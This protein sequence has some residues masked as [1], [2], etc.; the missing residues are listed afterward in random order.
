VFGPVPSRRLGRSLGV[1]LIPRKLCSYDCVYCQVGRTTTHTI[2]RGVYAPTELVVAELERKLAHKPGPDIVTFSGSGEPTL[3]ANIGEVLSW[4][5]SYS[6]HRT[7]VLT[8]GSLLWREDVRREL[9]MAD[10]V[11][12][13]LDAVTEAN[14]RRVNQPAPGLELGK[15][16]GGI[17]RFCAEHPGEV[18]LEVLLAK[19]YN[20]SEEE[21][22]AI[23]SEVSGLRATRVQVHTVTRPPA[24]HGVEGVPYETLARLAG[25]IGARAEI[26]GDYKGTTV[27]PDGCSEETVLAML[28]RRPCTLQDVADGLGVHHSEASKALGVLGAHGKVRIETVDGRE[29]FSKV[30]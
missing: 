10:L 15:V 11:V 8:N 30:E 5:K 7:A 27:L 29:Y 2:E 18:W 16:M 3:A 6:A 19:G 1:D 20:D 9:A 17:R 12:P 14:W 23:A 26:V 22:A 13:S 25:M 24:C 28:A 4:L 21:L